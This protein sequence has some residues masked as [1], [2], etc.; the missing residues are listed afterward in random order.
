VASP[1]HDDDDNDAG[2]VSPVPGRSHREDEAVEDDSAGHASPKPGGGTHRDDDNPH[3][4]PG[5]AVS[6]R[7]HD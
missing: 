2:H 4:T 6:Q 1:Q 3:G 5:P 7:S